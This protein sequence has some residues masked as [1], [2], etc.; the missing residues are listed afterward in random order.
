[1]HPYRRNGPKS[2]CSETKHFAAEGPGYPSCWADCGEPVVVADRCAACR[3]AELADAQQK[4][5][6]L[7]PQLAELEA[8][9][10]KLGGAIVTITI[11]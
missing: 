8:R 6:V 5:D 3:D 10:L 9:I 1:M 11:A 7:R 2:G 4:L